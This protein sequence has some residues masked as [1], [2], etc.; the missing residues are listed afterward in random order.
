M[1][2][3][4]LPTNQLTVS[5]VA[6][7]SLTGQLADKPTRGLDNSRTSQFAESEF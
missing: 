3:G 4:Q 7:L 5:Q 2:A 6:D 1:L